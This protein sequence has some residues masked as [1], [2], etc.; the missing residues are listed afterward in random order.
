LHRAAELAPDN[1]RFA[2]VY[3][4]ALERGGQDRLA[5]ATLENALKLNPTDR[6]SAAAVVAICNRIGDA[7]C[8]KRHTSQLPNESPGTR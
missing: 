6:E 5:I 1:P 2:Y 3:A 8:T 7:S 4:L